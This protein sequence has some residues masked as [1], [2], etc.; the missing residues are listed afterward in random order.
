VTNKT[1]KKNI[2][3][4]LPLLALLATSIGCG[5]KVVDFAPGG[6]ASPDA[7]RGGDS[8]ALVMDSLPSRDLSPERG[9]AP[10]PAPFCVHFMRTD[11]NALPAMCQACYDA[12]GQQVSNVCRPECKV[13]ETPDNTRCLYCGERTACLEC[14]ALAAQESCRR[15]W[16]T[17]MP[18]RLCTQCFTDGKVGMDDCD[19]LRPDLVKGGV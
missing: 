9:P 5:T 13:A 10:F 17:D 2:S 8:P 19:K 18:Q 3:I 1:V 14:R 4:A 7:G 15:C 12:W 16:W 11:G 6:D